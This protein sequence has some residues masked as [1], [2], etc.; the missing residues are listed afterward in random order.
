[1]QNIMVDMFFYFK[2]KGP[3]VW[4]FWTKENNGTNIENGHNAD[5]ACDSYNKFENDTQLLTNM[6]VRKYK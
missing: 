5:V 1:M 3:S 4:D 2:G 6:G